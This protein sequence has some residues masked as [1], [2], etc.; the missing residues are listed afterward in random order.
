[1]RAARRAPLTA[2]AGV[3]AGGVALGVTE[4]TAGATKQR[5]LVVT[6]GDWIIANA[7][8]SLVEY[9]K[10]TFGTNDKPALVGGIVIVALAFGALLG[11][12]SMR[13]PMIGVAGLVA[14]GV[15]GVLAAAADSQGSIGAA[16]VT[17]AVGCTFGIFTFFALL[18]A[19]ESPSDA[20]LADGSRRAFLR[21]AGAAAAVAG[22]S[23][24]AGR[25]LLERTARAAAAA[26]SH[27]VLPRASRP[28]APPGPGA[29][30]PVD[31][32][33]PLITANDRFYK[34]DTA[35]VYPEIDYEHWRL[36]IN[37]MVR[38][39]IELS[40]ADLL[41]MP[42]IE[43]YLTIACV[44]NEVGGDLVSTAAWRGVPLRDVLQRVG[45]D[46]RA[47]QVIGRSVDGFTVGFPTSAA[48][49]D[50]GAIVAIGMNGVPLPIAH[51]FPARLIVPGLYGYVSATKWL[52]N[53]E[54]STFDQFDA[55]WVE[56]GWAQQGPIKTQSRIDIPARTRRVR[57][58]R[59][60][61]AGAAWAP[62]RGIASVEV[63]IDDGPWSEARLADA[64]NADTWRQWIY[65][66]D[67][68]AGTHRL[69]VRATDGTGA[70]QDGRDHPPEPDGATGY[71]TIE[72]EVLA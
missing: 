72:V 23:A 33:T 6:V 62:T 45:V 11:M 26:R 67:A 53:I 48:L 22:A 19:T 39:P 15:A 63:Q 25:A 40:F 55:F 10:R 13:T 36:R 7:P 4:L 9:G 51:G 41:A 43:Q 68:P 65:T 46:P 52:T 1:M 29:L 54:L 56:R 58:G 70:L 34:I 35:L 69:R 59:V 31:G 49:D 14:F 71:H 57:A 21:L 47:D 20:R 61:I 30:V 42:L 60:P 44:S 2:L 24:L 37:G 5:S 8:H 18:R 66:W 3:L 64:L 28:I 50:R 16:A 38:R 12:L 27:V 32:V 17:A